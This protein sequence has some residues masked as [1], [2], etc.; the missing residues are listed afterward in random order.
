MPS[1]YRLHRAA[2]C[3]AVFGIAAVS[4]ASAEEIIIGVATAQTGGLAP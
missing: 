4:T 1:L 3:A 2:L